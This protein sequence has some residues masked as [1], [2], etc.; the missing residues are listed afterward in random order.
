MSIII[1]GVLTILCSNIL[2]QKNPSRRHEMDLP[3]NV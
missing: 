3:Y 2:Q 1:K